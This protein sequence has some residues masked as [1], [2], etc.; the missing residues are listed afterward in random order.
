MNARPWGWLSG[1]KA[2]AKPWLRAG[3]SRNLA[4]PGG[5]LL[6]SCN[7]HSGPYP[8]T[9]YYLVWCSTVTAGRDNGTAGP[10]SEDTFN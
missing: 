5:A 10:D 2:Q 6:D 9:Q 3:V 4:L 1:L 8:L 7:L